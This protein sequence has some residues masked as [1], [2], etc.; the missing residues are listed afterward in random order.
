MLIK[1]LER[2]GLFCRTQT[3]GLLRS[4][5]PEHK[6]RCVAV[7]RIYDKI[8]IKG[9]LQNKM[10]E[11]YYPCYGRSLAAVTVAEER[12][13]KSLMEHLMYRREIQ[14]IVLFRCP[15]T[16]VYKIQGRARIRALKSAVGRMIMCTH[17][18]ELTIYHEYFTSETKFSFKI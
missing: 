3:P 4:F 17:V 9:Y 8:G 7:T 15:L 2:M 6:D 13:I 14:L 11:Y 5:V 1:A 12:K 16:D 10:H 18:N